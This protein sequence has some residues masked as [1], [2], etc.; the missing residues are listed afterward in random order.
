MEN[1]DFR[2]KLWFRDQFRDARLKT[3]KD[4]EDFDGIIH[5]VEKLGAHL[6]INDNDCINKNK[7]DSLFDYKGHITKTFDL[8]GDLDRQYHSDFNNLYE[9]VRK[10]RNDALHQGV[11]A[12]HLASHA[13]KLAIIIEDAMNS[14]ITTVG[15]YMVHNPVCAS[16]WQPVS[17]V[18]QM[19][20]ENSFSHIPL[21]IDNNWYL[22]PDSSIAK[23]L[24]DSISENDRKERLKKSV[25][26]AQTDLV[27][28]TTKAVY[29][30]SDTPLKEVLPDILKG[31]VLIQQPGEESKLIG[32]I[33]AFDIL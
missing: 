25:H 10:A 3:L 17:F 31:P 20:L 18:R 22:I 33:T 19:M 7:C 2:W 12:R 26:S 21:Y 24:R 16:E 32:I 13:V 27:S 30:L 29:H 1:K 15:D 8:D 28:S 23:Y 11:R 5:L 6:C 4:A 9:L 14:D